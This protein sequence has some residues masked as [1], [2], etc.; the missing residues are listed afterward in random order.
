[1]FHEFY[2]TRKK[3]ALPYHQSGL[4]IPQVSGK[5][6]YGSFALIQTNSLRLMH[7]YTISN[8]RSVLIDV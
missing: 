4:P 2:H 5:E 8:N 3:E 1:M 6:E 7:I